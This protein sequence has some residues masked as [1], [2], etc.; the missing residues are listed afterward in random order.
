[1]LVEDF[2]GFFISGV[3]EICLN[4]QIGFGFFYVMGII[5]IFFFQIIVEVMLDFKGKVYL[6]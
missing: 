1:M 2:G 6:G 3:N 5:Y 4:D